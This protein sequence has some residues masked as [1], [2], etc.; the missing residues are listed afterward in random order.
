MKKN[1]IKLSFSSIIVICKTVRICR[2]RMLK[3][4]NRGNSLA[5]KTLLFIVF[6][7]SNFKVCK[8][9]LSDT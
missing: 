3:G 8:R 1:I 4:L 2:G 9:Y 7:L 5:K 6:S